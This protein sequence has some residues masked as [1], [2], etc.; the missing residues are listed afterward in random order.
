MARTAVVL[1]LVLAGAPN[2]LAD[3]AKPRAP[4]LTIARI[5]GGIVLDGRLTESAWRRAGRV[6]DWYETAPGDNV[7]PKVPTIGYLAYDE[8]YL[9]VGFDCRDPEPSRIRAPLAD[10]DG[11]TGNVDHAG[12]LIDSRN[13]GKT[14]M[15]FAASASGVQYDSVWDDSVATDDTAPDFYWDAAAHVDEAGWTLEMRIP[16]STVR[17]TDR[18]PASWRISLYR[19]YPREF[20]YRFVSATSP[21]GEDCWVCRANRLTGLHDLPPGGGLVVAPYLSGRSTAEGDPGSPLAP[22]AT[23]G[24]VGGDLKWT[25]TASQAFDITARPDFSQ[26]ESDA[27]QI[28]A[29]ERFALFYPEKRPFFLEG[30]D[31]LSTALQPFLS[32]TTPLQPIYTRTITSPEWG[33]RAT[34]RFGQTS[35]TVLA[36]N[37]RGGGSVILPAA[38]GSSSAPQDFRSNVVVG[39]IRRD[40]GSSFLGV[41]TTNRW[42]EGGGESHLF[43]P[44]FQWRPNSRDTVTGQW[45]VSRSTTPRRPDLAAEWDGRDLSGIAGELRWWHRTRHHDW[46]GDYRNVGAGF[47]ADNGFVPQV[48]YREGYVESGWTLWPTRILQRLRFFA[49]VDR[50]SSVQDGLLSR[51]HSA[52]VG[53]NGPR[54]SYGRIRIS[55]DRV[56]TGPVV[57]PRTQVVF[58]IGASPSRRLTSIG[59]TGTAGDAID[60]DGH[61]RGTGADVTVLASLQPSTHLEFRLSASRR[62]MD[63]TSPPGTSAR[64]FTAR[65]ERVRATYAFT[66]RVFLR[67]IAQHADT[68]RAA[69]LYAEGATAHDATLDLSALF[70]FKLNWQ[71]VLFA[72][73]GDARALTEDDRLEP[74]RRELF[75]KISY[76]FQR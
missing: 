19:I 62:L 36:A 34:G 61:R 52:G 72:G 35:Y 30:R 17:Y 76:A 25:P 5:E 3:T 53:F 63:V 31:L 58:D 67:L 12:I 29:N 45:L 4:D 64:L 6:E 55:F 57:L 9:Y 1:A 73:Y 39:R 26:I 2:A 8:R 13:D 28:S 65:I 38:T 33:G 41:V 70:S 59:L 66:R 23:S 20:W 40:F 37:D 16:F 75:A 32:L 56:R 24:L 11:L 60:F 47:R 14:A 51:Q 10:R 71:T 49:L 21:R 15:L 27:A 74:R 42:I 69:D 43:G 18:N 50:S 44:D 54:D 7:T 68:R 46:F 22:T 48:G